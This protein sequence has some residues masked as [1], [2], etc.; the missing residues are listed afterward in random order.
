MHFC[1]ARAQWRRLALDSVPG[2][3]VCYLS[4]KHLPAMRNAMHLQNWRK[5]C[6]AVWQNRKLLASDKFLLV[7]LFPP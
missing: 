4:A 7:V 3:I 2:W 6:F 5:N 1:L